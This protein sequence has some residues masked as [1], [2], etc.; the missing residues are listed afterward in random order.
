M[1]THQHS[2]EI[3]WHL[4]GTWKQIYSLLLVLRTEA[5]HSLTRPPDLQVADLLH[6]GLVL[7]A[8][9]GLAVV[10]ERALSLRAVL[11]RV[12]ELVEDGLEGVLEAGAPVNGTTTSSGRAG[13]VHPVHAVG[14]DQGVERLGGLLDSLV[15]SLR[16]A[17]ATLAENLVLG[18]EH[19][20]DTTHQAA[21]LTVQVRVD[22]LL[23]GGL[24]EV[25]TANGNTESDSLLFSLASHVLVDGEGG[26]DA[27]TLAEERADSAAGALGGAEDDVDVGGD[28]DLGEVLEDGRETVREVESLH[29]DLLALFYSYKAA[30]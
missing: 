15:E 11:D 23:E 10:V 1:T 2:V 16:G 29:K 18:K 13:L 6:L 26:V 21:T 25:T 4:T 19:T 27:T 7:L 24:V 14:T 17:V 5:A 12:V 9:V 20:V 22:L 8:V 28:L 30:G 3:H